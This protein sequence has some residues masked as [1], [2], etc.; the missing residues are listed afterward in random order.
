MADYRLP[1][2]D[3]GAWTV[4]QANWDDPV[5]AHTLVPTD[6]QSYAW[7]FNHPEGGNVR[8]A[9]AGKVVFL[10]NHD[11][12]VPAGDDVPGYGTAILIRHED[13][14]VAAYNHLLFQSPVVVKNQQVDEG[15]VIALSGDTGNSFAPHLHFGV[16][17]YW[18]SDDDKG[19]DLAI[20]F[21]DKNHACWRPRVGDILASDND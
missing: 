21:Q 10:E 15:E 16:L 20:R 13:D 5:A 14:T 4:G 19:E 17:S 18:V 11:G 8:A 12:N 3:D 1:F 6:G 2:D 9:R 7:D